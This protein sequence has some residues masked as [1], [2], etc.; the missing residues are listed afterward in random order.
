MKMPAIAT[1][2][3]TRAQEALDAF[4]S[5][6]LD[7]Q[8]QFVEFFVDHL[9]DLSRVF[10]GDLQLML[11][12]AI[13]GQVRIR[14]VQAAVQGGT[15]AAE[16]LL[17]TAGISASRLADITAIP[18]QTVRRKLLALE[19]RGWVKQSVDQAWYL[20]VRDGGASLRTELA[21][22]DTRAMERIAR[23]YAELEVIVGRTR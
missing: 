4:S 18:R 13:L 12:V 23:L 15:P 5:G 10:R 14:A 16:A 11:I 17:M 3:A 1:S 8:Y 6:Y 2:K 19:E 9:G 20:S 22:P 21:G 7:Y